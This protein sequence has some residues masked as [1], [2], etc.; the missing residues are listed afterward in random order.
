MR[1]DIFTH[2]ERIECPECP[3]VWMGLGKHRR[4]VKPN[5]LVAETNHSGCAVDYGV[6]PDCD[7]AFCVSYTILKIVRDKAWEEPPPDP[8]A[9]KKEAAERMEKEMAKV[10]T[11]YEKEVAAVD[12]EQQRRAKLKATQAAQ[13]AQGAA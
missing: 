13:A 9:E 4:L 2:G 12:E 11:E 7:K 10:R 5:L 3:G 8:E 1:D 6:C